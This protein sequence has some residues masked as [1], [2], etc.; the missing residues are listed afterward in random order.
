MCAARAI[1]GVEY[2][3]FDRRAPQEEHS[4]GVKSIIDEASIFENP[5]EV[6]AQQALR[7]GVLKE[8][9]NTVRHDL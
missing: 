7:K 2:S 9:N 5:D 6:H 1:L 8:A 4:R 3:S